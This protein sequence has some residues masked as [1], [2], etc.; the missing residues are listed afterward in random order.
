MDITK[1]SK[2]AWITT[3][4]LAVISMVY[5]ILILT[6]VLGGE[7]GSMDSMARFGLLLGAL[8]IFYSIKGIMY[9][10]KKER[11]Q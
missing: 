6:D 11:E 9:H 8:A 2:K 4:I 1:Y 5:D 7:D 10:V 3:L